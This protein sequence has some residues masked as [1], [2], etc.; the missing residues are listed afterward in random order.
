[1]MLG[2]LCE[3]AGFVKSNDNQAHSVIDLQVAKFMTSVLITD[4]W[5]SENT[6]AQIRRVRIASALVSP[7][8]TL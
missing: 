7:G 1:M 8:R 5:P 2:S 4:F 3:R 6:N